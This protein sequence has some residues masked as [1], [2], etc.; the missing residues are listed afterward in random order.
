M[1]KVQS[2]VKKSAQLRVYISCHSPGGD[3][4]TLAF[5]SLSYECFQTEYL[6]FASADNLLW[7]SFD[8][9]KHF[10]QFH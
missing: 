6:C 10:I 3:Y 8:E 5:S 7:F 2:T 9:H 1:K 4:A